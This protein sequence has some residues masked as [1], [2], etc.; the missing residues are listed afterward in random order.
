MPEAFADPSL[1]QL[2][3]PVDVDALVNLPVNGRIQ[4]GGGGWTTPKL[5]ETDFR[6]LGQFIERRPDA[7][8]RA[9]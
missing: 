9:F 7:K 6:N 1:V 5:T 8:F 2:S 3:S 4:F